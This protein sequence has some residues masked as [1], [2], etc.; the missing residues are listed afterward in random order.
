VI[1]GT[2]DPMFDEIVASDPRLTKLARKTRV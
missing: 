1:P 2:G